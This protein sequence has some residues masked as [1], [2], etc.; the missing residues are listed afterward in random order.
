MTDRE[1]SKA[2]VAGL[3]QH[4]YSV[5]QIARMLAVPTE[6]VKSVRAGRARLT[7]AQAARLPRACGL[8]AGQLAA[9]AM[10]VDDPELVKLID[11]WAAFSVGEGRGAKRA[12][13]NG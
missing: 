3:E 5:A 8:S 2:V 13:G 10:K 12:V 1:Y 11:M 7:D 9:Q 4:G 6:K